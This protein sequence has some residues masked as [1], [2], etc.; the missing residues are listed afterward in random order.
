MTSLSLG[1]SFPAGVGRR[2]GRLP[3]N[4]ATPMRISCSTSLLPNKVSWKDV[5]LENKKLI[6]MPTFCCGLL[7]QFKRV[8]TSVMIVPT[9]VGAAI[10]GYAGDAL[11][12]ARAL[13][14]VVDCLISH[15]NVCSCIKRLV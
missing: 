14:S 4:S 10:G 2:L 6:K 11:P 8:Y 12:V 9:G 1:R 15:P 7:K 5:Y 13:A 3:Q